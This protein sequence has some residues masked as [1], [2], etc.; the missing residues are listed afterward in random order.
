MRFVIVKRLS[1]FVGLF[2]QTANSQPRRPAKITA[3]VRYFFERLQPVRQL[4]YLKI[5]QI[6]ANLNSTIQSVELTADVF[7][8]IENN[9]SSC[10]IL[11]FNRLSTLVEV[12]GSGCT[13]CR[14]IRTE[15]VC[16]TY[17]PDIY[18]YSSCLDTDLSSSSAL[19]DI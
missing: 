16:G 1:E 15:F 3:T 8:T 10:E 13:P 19:A 4:F 7:V 9:R 5:L 11:R 18:E 14:S 17:A 6:R 2:R 12:I